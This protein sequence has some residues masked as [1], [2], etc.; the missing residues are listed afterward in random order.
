MSLKKQ[1]TTS[2]IWTVAASLLN[3]LS[4]FVVFVVLAR[5]LA[6]G[7]F[8]IVAFATVFIEIGRTLVVAGISDA[9]VQRAEW[10][11]AVASTA[12]W[13]NLAA[14]VVIALLLALAGAGIG[15]AGGGTF[16]AVLSVLALSLVLEGAT[17]V[18]VAKLRRDFRYKQLATR[19]MIG[20][21][22]SGAIGV[23]LAYAGW[24][25]WAL[26]WS[27]L[28][29][30]LFYSAVIWQVS[31]FH[32]QRT[33]SRDHARAMMPFAAGQLGTQLLS[34]GNAQ[35]GALVIGALLGPAA[36]AQ[37]RVGQR[38]LGIIVSLVISP[39]QQT[40][41]SAFSRLQGREDGIGPAYLRLTRAC[42]LVSCPTLF[43]LAA[44]APDFVALV[45]GPQWHIAGSVMIA[46]CLFAGPA[47]LNYFQNPALSAAGRS[48]LSF[49]ATLS[50]FV[51]NLLSALITIPFGVIW[52]AAG[53]TARAH[54]TLP[55]NLHFVRRGIGV[56]WQDALGNIAAPYLCAAA[57][58]AGVTL[59]RIEA[60]S[61]FATT[62]RLALCVVAGGV[63]Y[64][65]FLLVFARGFLR[66]N[67]AELRPLLPS[68]VRRRLP[69]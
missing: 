6:P 8:G 56:P 63:L 66:A 65:G 64:V 12:F 18:H 15:A 28:L 20:R 39:L 7:E 61:A 3:N 17:A 31:D 10:D 34:Q 42:A 1:L 53:Q 27:G 41:L 67:W 29:G 48:D 33:F 50:G 13:L 52:V 9:L 49:W 14:G 46:L 4:S 21:L 19:G 40:A 26:V 43:G 38:A 24:G 45:F 57:M 68:A 37:F 55:I 23:A 25:V 47:T 22:A 36:I 30:S 58:F 16:A 54:L 5:L 51:G 62:S 44:V 32:P 69:W 2:S 11:Q 60:L 59:L 35:A